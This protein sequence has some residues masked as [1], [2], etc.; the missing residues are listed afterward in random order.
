MEIG[1]EIPFWRNDYT[2]ADHFA[3][4]VLMNETYFSGTLLCFWQ[5]IVVCNSPEDQ[6]RS[7]DFTY[8]LVNT[9]HYDQNIVFQVD[10]DE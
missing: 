8:S 2:T 1:G 6:V 10:D 7:Q 5:V 9:K 4:L 3:A